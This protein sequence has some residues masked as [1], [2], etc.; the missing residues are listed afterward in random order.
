MTA[1]RLLLARCLRSILWALTSISFITIFAFVLRLGIYWNL[2]RSAPVPLL[3]TTHF[4]YE[5]GNIASSIAR[6][7]GFSS[8]I[9][10]DTGPTAWL[11]PVYPYFLAAI[12]RVFGIYSYA[13]LLVSIAFNCVFSALTCI[14]IYSIGRRLGGVS[15]GAAAAWIWTGFMEAILIP[16]Q[17]VWDTSLT[18]LVFACIMWATLE[19]CESETEKHW[20]YYG[21]LW[22]L[23]LMVNAALLSVMPFIFLWLLLR[24]YK[25]A[26]KL[27]K[28][29]ATAGLIVVCGC[30]PWTIRNYVT[31]H[32]L[33]PLRSNFGLELWLGNNPKV[34]DTWAGEL[35]PNEDGP[36]HDLYLRLGEIKYMD[37]KQREALQFMSSHPKDVSRFFWRRFAQT[38]TGTW[39]PI[40]DLWPMA[41]PL[42]RIQIV[43][44]CLVSLGSLVGILFL[45]REKSE[46]AFPLAI[47]PI[48]F[49]IVYYV[50]HPSRRYRH[51]IDPV[52]I[53]LTSITLCHAFSLLFQRNAIHR[54]GIDELTQRRSDAVA[55]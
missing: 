32:K 11:T 43:S 37:L 50:T 39:E 25:R 48:A 52:L 26:R 6:G 45:Y 21:A 7:Q 31:L 10:G 16:M 8:P 54:S 3:G 47:V 13:S 19:I 14:P 5:T 22:V 18:A 15:A 27:W 9:G 12:F 1:P 4:G 40:A 51:P 49:P 17:W 33:L 55:N 29:P 53:V 30:V 44:N 36:E 20:M 34:P 41:P 2:Q 24:N 23:G 38:W 28:L 42:L 46:F 35:H